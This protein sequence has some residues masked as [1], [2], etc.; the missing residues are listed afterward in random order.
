M[1]LCVVEDAEGVAIAAGLFSEVCGIVQFHLSGTL[2]E[3]R[4]D[5]P[6]RVMLDFVRL[7]AKERGN[8]TFHLGGGL[9]AQEDSLWEFKRGF[10]EGRAVFRSWR[11]WGDPDARADVME[12]WRLS[13]GLSAPSPGFF[14][15]YRQGI[16]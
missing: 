16:P 9:G 4:D 10:S 13:T 2:P 15:P 12:R 14:P 7:W 5:S 3:R 8:R 6:S 1:H 11:L